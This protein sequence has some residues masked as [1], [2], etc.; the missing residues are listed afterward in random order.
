MNK[1]NLVTGNKFKFRQTAAKNRCF[2][3]LLPAMIGSKITVGNSKWEVLLLLLD[4]HDIAMCPVFSMAYTIILDD[5]VEAF[6]E[7]FSKEFPNNSFKPKMHYL[8]HYGSHGRSYGPLINYWSFR[9][10]AKHHYFKD[11]ANRLKCRRNIL[12]TLI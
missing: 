11:A 6:S 2:L 10:E 4:V 5:S 3:R 9:F 12:K 8:T 7:S 1:P